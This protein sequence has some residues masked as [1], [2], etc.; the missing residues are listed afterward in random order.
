[1]DILGTLA[2]IYVALAVLAMLRTVA[3]GIRGPDATLLGTLTG[4]L[5]SI[6]WLPVFI[7]FIVL[8]IRQSGPEDNGRS[9]LF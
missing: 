5:L 9:H 7:V 4:C 3:E 8:Q 1:M 6:L 2:T